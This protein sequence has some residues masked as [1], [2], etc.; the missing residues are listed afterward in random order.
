MM[1]GGQ[2]DEPDSARIIA[3]AKDAGINFIDT[4]DVYNDGASEEVAGRAISADRRH[5]VLATK[6]CNAM[7][8]GPNQVGLSRRWMFEA[9][10][11][12]LPGSAPTGS[13]SCTSTG[14][15]TPRRSRRRSARWR[16]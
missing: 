15:T 2:T 9:C 12:S 14:R 13:T 4:A 7:G 16:T 6:M 3:R 5:W 10:D 11:G 1:F 8:K